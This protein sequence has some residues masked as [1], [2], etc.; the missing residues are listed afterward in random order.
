MTGR[1]RRLLKE[2]FWAW[3]HFRSKTFLF[4]N[5]DFSLGME[6]AKGKKNCTK[7]GDDYLAGHSQ[8]VSEEAKEKQQAY[9]EP[10]LPG[11]STSGDQME[12]IYERRQSFLFRKDGTRKEYKSKNSEENPSSSITFETV[13]TLVASLRHPA[14]LPGAKNSS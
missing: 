11:T 6:K 1:G 5:L 2:Q 14:G 13:T 12:K 9:G 8:P 3:G 4:V 7:W 10:K